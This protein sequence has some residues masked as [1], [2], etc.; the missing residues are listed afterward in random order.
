MLLPWLYP[1]GNDDFNE[2]RS[3]DIIIK[4]WESQQ[5]YMADGLFDRDRTWCLYDLHYAERRR[6]Q[7]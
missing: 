3:V 6:N 4:D 5:L 2:S 1:C 7:V